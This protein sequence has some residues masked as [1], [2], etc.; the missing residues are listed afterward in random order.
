MPTVGAFG[1]WLLDELP[2]R[3][4]EVAEFAQSIGV[5]P[6]TIYRWKERDP[7]LS[8][9]GRVAQELDLDYYRLRDRFF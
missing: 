7:R 9:V 8:M 4:L 5:C 1:R 3:G 2:A 6:S